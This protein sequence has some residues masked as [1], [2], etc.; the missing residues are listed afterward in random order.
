MIPESESGER[1]RRE[2]TL[3]VRHK[4]GAT[5]L[6]SFWRGS[7]GEY[8]GKAKVGSAIGR[9]EKTLCVILN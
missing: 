3:C 8:S 6:L 1:R 9:R 7:T 4:R 2:R 5:R